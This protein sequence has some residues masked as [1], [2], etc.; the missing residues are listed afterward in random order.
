[1]QII[2]IFG[3]KNSAPTRAAERFFKERGVKTQFIDLRQKFISPGE[4]RRFTDKFTL[5]GLLDMS[6]KSYEDAGLKYLKVSES[7]LLAK[8]EADPKLF[9]LP[10][11]RSS[12]IISIGQDEN[13]WKSMLESHA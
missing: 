3:I 2:Q 9:R 5:N 12:K 8:I 10:L 6:G 7:E 1:M 13:L 4:L 11:V